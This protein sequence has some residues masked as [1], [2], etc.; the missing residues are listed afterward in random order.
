MAARWGVPMQL[1][2]TVFGFAIA[3]LSVTGV[4][5][6]ARKRRSRHVAASRVTTVA[7]PPGAA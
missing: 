4:W 7:A 6:W 3:M 2:M 1:F 5:I